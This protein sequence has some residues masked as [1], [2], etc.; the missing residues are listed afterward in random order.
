LT[1]MP[2]G[3]QGSPSQPTEEAERPLFSTVLRE[4]RLSDKVA[5]LI[6]DT[7]IQER[8]AAGERLPSEREL[9]TQFGVSRTVIREA[10]RS[11]AAK[12]LVEATG[13]RGIR[14]AAPNSGAM[15]ETLSLYLHGRPLPYEKVHEVRS[16][17]EIEV[18]G[19]AAKRKSAADLERL[20]L[21]IDALAEARDDHEAAAQADVEFHRA[22]AE[23]TQNELYLIMLDSIRD[24]LLDNRRATMQIPG[25]TVKGA[26]AHRRIYTAVAAGDA[27]GARDAMRRHLE[28][29]L[30]TWQRGRD[31]GQSR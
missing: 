27:D 12:G 17:I 8:M 24:L 3:K 18:A 19:L 7:I 10:V 5:D 30:R 9:G 15:A 13:G 23:G 31:R 14:V 29:S 16:M 11:L 4:P 28:D 21:L 26:R 22:L 6:R 25:R 2:S 1:S 20:D